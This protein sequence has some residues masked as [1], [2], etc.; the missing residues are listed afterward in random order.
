MNEMLIMTNYLLYTEEKTPII[1]E[2]S[3]KYS[4]SSCCNKSLFP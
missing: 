2:V 3:M 4:S 1:I